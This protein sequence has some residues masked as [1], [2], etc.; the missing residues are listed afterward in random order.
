MKIISFCLFS[1]GNSNNILALHQNIFSL[2]PT[3]VK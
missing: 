1:A 3:C 2:S